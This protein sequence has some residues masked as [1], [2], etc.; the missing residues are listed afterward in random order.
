MS[1]AKRIRRGP[2]GRTRSVVV[3]L[4]LL[5]GVLVVAAPLSSQAEDPGAVTG[6]AV[7]QGDGYATVRCWYR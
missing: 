1:P 7:V 5:V 2:G 4:S 6:V 3:S